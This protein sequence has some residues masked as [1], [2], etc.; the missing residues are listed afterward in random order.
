MTNLSELSQA[1]GLPLS[2]AIL[3]SLGFG[4]AIIDRSSGLYRCDDVPA[5]CD[6]LCARI[7]HARDAW[8]KGRST[9]EPVVVEAAQ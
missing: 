5:I 3:E 4:P 1:I 6:A 8:I 7:T 2:A 9:A